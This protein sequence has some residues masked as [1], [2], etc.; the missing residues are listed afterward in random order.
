MMKR[1]IIFCIFHTGKGGPSDTIQHAE[2]LMRGSRDIEFLHAPALFL[3]FF[4]ASAKQE[5]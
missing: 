5:A 4:I 3:K 2:P 1:P